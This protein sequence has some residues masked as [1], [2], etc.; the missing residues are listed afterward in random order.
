MTKVTEPRGLTWPRI[1]RTVQLMNGSAQESV[2]EPTGL[3]AG[4]P[5]RF[6]TK[7][8]ARIAFY[9]ALDNGA[10]AAEAARLIGISRTTAYQWVKHHKSVKLS[11]VASD[12]IV[13]KVE[14]AQELSKLIRRED[15]DPRDKIGAIKTLNEQMGYNAPT[16]SEVTQ[17]IIPASVMSWLAESD[18]IDVTPEPAQLDK[19]ATTKA[20]G[21]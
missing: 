3:S 20:L 21:E 2:G 16:R 4:S 19:P 1:G 14:G 9:V 12:A 13:S 10:T 7:A 11:K 15:I 5:G 6:R 17:R 18:V 8:E